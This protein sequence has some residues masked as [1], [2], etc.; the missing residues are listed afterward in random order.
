MKEVTAGRDIKQ[1]GWGEE[2]R[3]L[4]AGAPQGTWTGGFCCFSG[5]LLVLPIKSVGNVLTQKVFQRKLS[6]LTENPDKP[7]IARK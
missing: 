3:E 6:Q 7:Y 4:M 5:V 1:H 2:M